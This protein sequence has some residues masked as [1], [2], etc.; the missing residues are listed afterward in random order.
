MLVNVDVEKFINDRE[1]YNRQYLNYMVNE[2][3]R[4][5]NKAMTKYESVKKEQTK[6]RWLNIIQKADEELAK[7]DIVLDGLRNEQEKQYIRAIKNLATQ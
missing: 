4:S 5:K 3:N 2:W 1:F 6:N 7:L